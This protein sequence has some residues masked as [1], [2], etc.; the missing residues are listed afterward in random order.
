MRT[1]DLDSWPRR[2]HFEFFKGFEQPFFNLCAE[3]DVTAVREAGR[4]SGGPSFFVAT[5]WASLVAANE[6]EE[7]RYR[8]RGDRVVVHDR[9]HGGGTVLRPD[10]TFGFGY[11]DFEDDFE[12]F[13]QQTEA[14]LAATRE[15]DDLDPAGERDD[16]IYYS[17]IPWIS[18]TSFAHARSGFP[19]SVPRLVFGR[20]QQRQDRWWM[21]VSVEVHHALVD[22]IHVGR[23]YQRM[24]EVLDDFGS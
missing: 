7:L 4:R 1:L 9:I 3:V 20:Y 13:E 10:E 19:S 21:P 23:F 2:R 24:Q 18:F 16:L 11:F 6:V 17:V 8:I 12:L 5:L 22:G 14:S 15:G